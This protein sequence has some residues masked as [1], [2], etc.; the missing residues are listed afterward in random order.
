MT[1]SYDTVFNDSYARITDSDGGDRFFNHFYQLFVHST[2]EIEATFLEQDEAQLRKIVYKTFFFML[3]V[4]STHNVS[5]YLMTISRTQDAEGIKLPPAF[6]AHWRRAV[7]QTV[8]QL[9]P[10]CDEDIITAWAMVIAPGLEYMRR[11]AE[12]F[13]A[14]PPTG[15]SP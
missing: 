13:H 1:F 5:N 3:S 14:K 4:S 8:R 11:Q 10:Q 9:D 6:Y 2:A 12:L 7:L 15:V